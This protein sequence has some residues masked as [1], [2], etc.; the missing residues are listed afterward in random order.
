MDNV[1]DKLIGRL[2]GVY[3]KKPGSNVHK[4]MQLTAHHIQEN[5]DL[6]KKISDWR[7]IDQAEGKVLDRVGQNVQQYRG[8]LPD[9]TFR[10]LIKAKIKRG[11]SD[12]SVDTLIDFISFV[13]QVD[14]TDVWVR[15][16]WPEGKH[17]TIH[18]T[19]PADA[20]VATGLT[21]NQ[22]GRLINEIVVAGVRAEVLFEGTFAFSSNYEGSEFDPNAGFAND[23]QT[24]G[25]TLGYAYD[26]VD[27]VDLPL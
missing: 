9:E 2:T 7:D 22:F 18:V 1:L 13:L 6:Y 14:P 5:E 3:N 23:E 26:P 12:G 25:G 8:Q 4:L 24:T 10:V 27:Y 20:I 21:L 17:A 11:L 16:L 15:E 19:T